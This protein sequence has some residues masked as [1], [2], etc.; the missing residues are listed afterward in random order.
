MMRWR[1]CRRRVLCSSPR[2]RSLVTNPRHHPPIFTEGTPTR[3]L[4]HLQCCIAKQVLFRV[5]LRLLQL[6]HPPLQCDQVVLRFVGARPSKSWCR[7]IPVPCRVATAGNAVYHTVIGRDTHP[8]TVQ[9]AAAGRETL[10]SENSCSLM[11]SWCFQP[12]RAPVSALH[13]GASASDTVG[14]SASRSII[15]LSSESTADRCGTTA[16]PKRLVR[17]ASRSIKL[18]GGGHHRVKA[19]PSLAATAVPLSSPLFPLDMRNG[20]ASLPY[21]WSC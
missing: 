15:P 19:E 6:S 1:R 9:P 10:G 5:I 4:F 20:P 11:R 12:V 16:I 3:F 8:N 13:V 14:S 7:Y 2:Q 17:W 21:R 18:C